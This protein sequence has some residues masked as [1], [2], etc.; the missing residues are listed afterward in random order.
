MPKA[1][2]HLSH[3]QTLLAD[4]QA[5]PDVYLPRREILIEWLASFLQRAQLAGY[6]LG[7]TE[8][9]DLN[10]VELLLREMKLGAF[11]SRR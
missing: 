6:R 7:E 10:A 4:I 1:S 9:A 8:A 5:A 11:G 2:A 3:A